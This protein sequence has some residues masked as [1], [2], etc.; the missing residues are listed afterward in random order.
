MEN[1]L[2][3]NRHIGSNSKQC[4][5][6]TE[7]HLND[8]L[9]ENAA[10]LG[11]I[12]TTTNCGLWELRD[13]SIRRRTVLP[14]NE[15]AAFVDL[16]DAIGDW[17]VAAGMYSATV[18]P[19]RRMY[20][21]IR[22]STFGPRRYGGSWRSQAAWLLRPQAWRKGGLGRFSPMACSYRRS[23]RFGRGGQALTM[24]SNRRQRPAGI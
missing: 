14:H 11:W 18:P 7:A 15:P 6:F 12:Q 10:L 20:C 13:F 23:N 5:L 2:L 3:W 24:F 8:E 21:S 9:A 19:P 22:R 1:P 16:Y 4:C 17:F